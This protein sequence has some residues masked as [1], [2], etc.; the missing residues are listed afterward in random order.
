[1]S[2]KDNISDPSQQ[3]TVNVKSSIE[4]PSNSPSPSLTPP[5]AGFVKYVQS[6]Q[7][8][9]NISILQKTPCKYYAN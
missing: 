6:I 4:T 1:M 3:L 7:A 5:K 8:R 2:E 9:S